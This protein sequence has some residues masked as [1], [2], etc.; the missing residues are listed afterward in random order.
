MLRVRQPNLGEGPPSGLIAQLLQRAGIEVVETDESS[1]VDCIAQLA[2]DVISAH[3]APV[4]VNAAAA[5]AQ[6]PFVDNLHGMYSVYGAEWRWHR[7][8]GSGDRLTAVVVVSDLRRRDYLAGNPGLPPERVVAIPNG[9]SPRA[10]LSGNC[11]AV[12]A[13]LGLSDEFLFVSFYPLQ[14]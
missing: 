5:R 9:V 8:A 6:V 12:R 7:E 2:P 3:G 11:T 13:R 14:P 1:L 4:S 10:Q